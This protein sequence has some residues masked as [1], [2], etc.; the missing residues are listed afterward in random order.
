VLEFLRNKALQNIA[1]QRLVAHAMKLCDELV[2]ANQV[3]GQAD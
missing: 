3:F 2:D 1:H